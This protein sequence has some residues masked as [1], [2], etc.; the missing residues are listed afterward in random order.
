MTES[1]EYYVNLPDGH[2]SQD[3][4]SSPWNFRIKATDE[5]V[6]ELRDRIDRSRSA[7]SGSFWRAHIPF[8]EYHEDEANDEYDTALKQV[9]RLIH[10]LGDAEAQAHIEQMGIL[11]G[12]Q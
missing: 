9:Y 8:M 6:M 7:D 1:K 5:Q 12:E 4:K 2:I 11:T 3:S 10:L